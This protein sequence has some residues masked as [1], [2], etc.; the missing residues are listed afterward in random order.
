MG[1][2][3]KI[4]F[5]LIIIV[6]CIIV[7]SAKL[8]IGSADEGKNAFAFE[9]MAVA[10]FLIPLL[11]VTGILNIYGTLSLVFLLSKNRDIRTMKKYFY[12]FAGVLGS[13]PAVIILI[14]VLETEMKSPTNDTIVTPE[15]TLGITGQK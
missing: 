2:N 9:F 14:W 6:A 10:L 5:N 8:S 12:L 13:F 3:R 7:V 15:Q 4:L 11:A 1:C